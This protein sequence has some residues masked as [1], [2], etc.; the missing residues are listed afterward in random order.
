MATSSKKSVPS[1]LAF[2]LVAWTPALVLL[3]Q[4][5]QNWVDIPFMDEWDVGN[6]FLKFKQGTLSFADLI[7]QHNESRFFFPHLILMLLVR[8]TRW[9][10]RVPILLLFATVCVISWLL[11]KLLRRIPNLSLPAKLAAMFAVNLLLFSPSQHES[12]LM[13]LNF[14][15]VVPSAMLACALLINASAQPIEGKVIIGICC[16]IFSTFSNANGMEIWPLAFGGFAAGETASPQRKWTWYGVYVAAAAAAIWFYFRDYHPPAHHPAFGSALAT[17]FD[18]A[19]FFFRWLGSSI[20]VGNNEIAAYLGAA[21][22]TAFVVTAAYVWWKARDP[23]MR[24]V[25]YVWTAIGAYALIAGVST[26]MGRLGLGLQTAY[27]SRYITFSVYLP[28]GLIG[29]F[30]A[31]AAWRQTRETAED[32]ALRA[33]VAACAFGIILVLALGTF[34]TTMK[35]MA[36][37]RTIRVLG[38]TA[39]V[40]SDLMPNNP[41]LKR[42]HPN[43]EW[44]KN[45]YRRFHD[46][47]FIRLRKVSA[48]IAATHFPRSGADATNGSL[49]VC[50]VENATVKM[51]GSVVRS[52][53]KTPDYILV[54]RRSDTNALTPVAALALDPAKANHEG[55]VPFELFPVVANLSPG[56]CELTVWAVDSRHNSFGQLAHSRDVIIP[57]KP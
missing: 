51:V 1:P 15:L 49:D 47:G 40:F 39:L 27:S 34:V 56:P 54:T 11:W 26:S 45:Q 20:S 14:S 22:L 23:S 21:L 53:S 37:E 7:G 28:I 12:W 33:P 30:C 44:A 10:A 57:V 43:S 32:C 41:D 55:C 46:A 6:V 17:P 38:T 8:W 31:L 29:L 48:A 50:H 16:G 4:L 24:N 19:R 5:V 35:G 25:C 52:K 18:L 36:Y 9:D 3:V 42:L 13:G 2:G